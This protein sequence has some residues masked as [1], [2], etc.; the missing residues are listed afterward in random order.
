[1][2]FSRKRE[3]YADVIGAEPDSPP[4]C[5]AS[6]GSLGAPAERERKHP[7]QRENMMIF[8][9]FGDL[10]ATHPSTQKRIDALQQAKH[11]NK[12]PMT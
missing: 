2:T 5:T 11:I 6:Y 9:A 8:G 12:L 1:M 4:P 7:S 3:F 10:F